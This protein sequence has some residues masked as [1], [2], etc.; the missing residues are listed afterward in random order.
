M[1]E[2]TTTTTQKTNKSRK[3]DKI[4][5]F[6]FWAIIIVSVAFWSGVYI[7]TQVTL[8]NINDKESAKIK[9]IE[10]YKAS[11]KTSKQ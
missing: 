6:G 10:E 4:Q 7:G 2:K 1:K 8:N 11:L 5:K 3:F 9:A